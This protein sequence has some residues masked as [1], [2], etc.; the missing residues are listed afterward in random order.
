MNS[1]RPCITK[2]EVLAF[3]SSLKNNYKCHM[4]TEIPLSSVAND[5]YSQ[6]KKSVKISKTTCN[7]SLLANQILRNACT[8]HKC[9][10]MYPV[11]I[12]PDNVIGHCVK[13]IAIT[14]DSI[15]K[16]DFAI[17]RGEDCYYF[18]KTYGG[19][20]SIL[21]FLDGLK[22]AV[23][24]RASRGKFESNDEMA[25]YIQKKCIKARCYPV[26]NCKSHQFNEG[27]LF[28]DDS[29]YVML[30]YIKK[31]N[32]E[33][34]LVEPNDCYDLEDGEV[35]TM[36]VSV[37]QDTEET[38]KYKTD[39]TP[40]LAFFNDIVYKLKMKSSRAFYS[41]VKTLK[42]RNVFLLDEFSSGGDKLGRKECINNGIL[43]PLHSR[44]ANVPVYSIKF[45]VKIGGL[46][47]TL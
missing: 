15:L 2:K 23:T 31:Y 24:T 26:E 32:E 46:G 18:G 29:K 45:T 27:M 17:G 33:D 37:I 38:V 41:R 40:G 16:V 1:R 25:L 36:N 5:I 13:D 30:N 9:F 14:D 35:Y 20:E 7:L 34:Y 44:Y 42:G 43:E 11:V 4:N 10:V 3:D 12:S 22:E 21:N 39:F 6:I 19:D 47:T 28:S 8:E